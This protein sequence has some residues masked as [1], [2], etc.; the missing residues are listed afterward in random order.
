MLTGRAIGEIGPVRFDV[1]PCPEISLPNRNT[2]GPVLFDVSKDADSGSEDIPPLLPD[3]NSDSDNTSSDDM[4][5]SWDSDASNASLGNIIESQRH[6]VGR[7]RALPGSKADNPRNDNRRLQ[8]KERKHEKK[9]EQAWRIAVTDNNDTVANELQQELMKTHRGRSLF[10]GARKSE[11]ELAVYRQLASNVKL[12]NTGLGQRS[13][14][15][16]HLAL[17]VTKDLPPAFCK[18]VLAFDPALIRQ[19]RKRERD[20]PSAPALVTDHR[21]ENG[22]ARWSPEFEIELGNFFISRTEILSGAKTNTRRLLKPKGRVEAELY[23]EF[24]AVLRQAASRD[25]DMLPD[26]SKPNKVLTSMQKN[27]LASIHAATQYSFNQATEYKT[28]LDTELE[29]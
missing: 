20:N 28:R 23:A 8:Y 4:S 14:H 17:K 2:I 16:G 22:R 24:P 15:R 27:L 5:S 18:E 6:V 10:P 9:L 13:K 19:G 12:L 11:A 7:P 29:R 1:N 3:E 25:P 21:S 26:S